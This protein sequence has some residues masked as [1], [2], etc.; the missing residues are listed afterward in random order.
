MLATL[1]G[2]AQPRQ[3][4][5]QLPLFVNIERQA[6][7]EIHGQRLW[8][9]ADALAS[10]NQG[11]RSV[12]CLY[13]FPYADVHEMG[14]SVLVVGDS[15]EANLDHVAQQMA[16]HWWDMRDQFTGH[17]ISIEVAIDDCLKH[18]AER[19]A[20]PVGLLDMGDNVG[21]G[22]PGDGTQI[23]HHWLA[24]GC[25]K[26]IL[27]VLYDPRSA[28]AAWESGAGTTIDIQVGGNVDPQRHGAPIRG[29]FH[30]QSLSDG[31]FT[32]TGTTH[33]GY[34]RFNQGKTAFLKGDGGLNILVT[35]L[36][37]APLSIQQLLSQEVSPERFTAIVIKGVHAPV[38]AYSAYCSRFIRV[39][40]P[41]VTTADPRQLHYAHSRREVLAS[42]E[43]G[44]TQPR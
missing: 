6:T 11:I 19:P 10:G 41:G 44:W 37:V 40:T 27:A 17:L 14:A 42:A 2:Q 26:P 43:V 25:E 34:T 15:R 38:A 18:M 4:L 28:Q 1:R 23:L 22:S 12:S 24:R 5:I 21:G 16:T 30:V 8:A 7:A 31:V 36:R 32:E 9:V 39:N 3:K 35:S 13:G 20:L 29:R 33:G